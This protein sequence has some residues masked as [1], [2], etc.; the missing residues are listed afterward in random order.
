MNAMPEKKHVVIIGGGFGGL[1]A[2]R[3]LRHA[4][5]RVTL[6]DRRNFHLFQPLLYQVATAA[7]SP[8]NIASPLRYILKN[9]ANT[10]VLLAE[11]TDMDVR[12]KMVILSDGEVPYDTLIVAAGSQTNYFG[13]TDWQDNAPGL[14]SLEDATRL[15][16][17]ILYA[18]EQA[19]R[20]TDPSKRAAW[21]TFVLV[22]AGP[23]GVELAGSLGEIAGDTL[24]N[25][26]RSIETDT[27]RILLI[28]AV[29]RVLSTY[30]PELSEKALQA[31]NKL[32]VT[33]EMKSLVT[34][35]QKGEIRV[36]KDGVEKTIKANTVMWAAGVQ[37]SPLGAQL[38]KATGIP[39]QKGGRLR[40]EPDLTLAG[41][42][43]IF[44]IGDMAEHLGADGKPLPG[45]APVA[46]QE[47]RYAAEL[48]AERTQGKSLPPFEYH[49][50]GDM[51]TIG[52][53]SAVA[54]LKFMKF[55]GFFAWV[56]WLF[57]HLWYIVEFEDRLLVFT[58]WAWNYFTRNRG[59]R[60]ITNG[61]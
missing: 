52:R 15:R 7:L 47:G 23:T 35:I 13:H 16:R 6:I 22:G 60:L 12:R 9:Q 38:S 21:L 24:C 18:F 40:V 5:V 39:L 28:D 29:D 27:A 58:Q 59:A 56:A 57:I 31:L 34:S 1:Y 20:E 43:D 17:R 41:F 55:N 61:Q 14:K 4:D 30:P 33:V 49:H 11:V 45:I 3:S 25:E 32:G 37:A 44:V 48:I 19:E 26:F 51:A 8:A 36:K 46:M 2:A 50:R 42:P 10:R 54:N 53:A